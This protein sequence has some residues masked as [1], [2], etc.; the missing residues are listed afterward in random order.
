M[1]CQ[2]ATA[3]A[4]ED[5]E[6]VILGDIPTERLSETDQKRLASFVAD[7]GGFLVLIGGPKAMPNSYSTGP[8]ADL[9]PIRPKSAAA[10]PVSGAPEHVR[11]KL[12]PSSAAHEITR[13]FRDPVLNEKLWPAL[14]E[15]H[16]VARPAYAKPLATP[17]LVTD[18]ARR[19]V[20][21]AVQNYGA[22]RVLYSGT[23]GTWGWR[24]KVADRIHAFFWSQA[25]RW[26]TS[27]RLS[28][29]TRLKIGCDR[30]KVSSRRHG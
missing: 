28:G 18:D 1:R 10:A 13:I 27:N 5:Y 11:V 25:M 30:R 23:D 16:W 22:G 19:D 7:R 15:L 3:R 24:Y 21:I 8:I 4:E 17:L 14:P 26:G 6:I 9:L 29:G 12:D 20:V 2:K